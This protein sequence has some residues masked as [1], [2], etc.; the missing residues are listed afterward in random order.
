MTAQ[1]V[2]SKDILVLTRTSAALVAIRGRLKNA[3]VK[4]PSYRLL[5]IDDWALHLI[6]ALP[7]R[8][9]QGFVALER[10]RRNY[11]AIRMAAYELLKSGHVGEFIVA[12]YSH[13]LVDKNQDYSLRQEAIVY[14]TSLVLPSCAVGEHMRIIIEGGDDLIAD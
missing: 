5:T 8:A 6:G 7:K 4:P 10:R 1:N 13:L 14:Y 11:L 3:G 2:E 9:D 12:N